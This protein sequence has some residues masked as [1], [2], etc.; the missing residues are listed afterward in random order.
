[1]ARRVVDLDSLTAAGRPR[2]CRCKQVGHGAGLARSAVA[3]ARFFAD[4]GARVTVYDGRR[5]QSW[6]RRLNRSAARD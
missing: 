5:P 6:L 2:R 3:L 1:M 4:A